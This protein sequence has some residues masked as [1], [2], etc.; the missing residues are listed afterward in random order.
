MSSLFKRTDLLRHAVDKY[1]AHYSL[2]ELK[3]KVD[4]KHY[5]IHEAYNMFRAA[6]PDHTKYLVDGKPLQQ[7]QFKSISGYMATLIIEEA[8][9]NPYGFIL[10]FNCGVLRPFKQ[11]LQI[12]NFRKAMDHV[13]KD[14][15]NKGKY[16]FM[17]RWVRDN[18]YSN[19]KFKRY[20]RYKPSDKIKDLFREHV[21]QN[22]SKNIIEATT[23]REHINAYIGYNLADSHR[24]Q[25]K[26]TKWREK[27]SSQ[28]LGT[29]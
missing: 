29:P 7:K 1:K 15:Y 18:Y 28:D 9:S 11:V 8:I 20:Y 19:L 4:Y 16:V 6:Y 26:I 21:K 5:T 25:S 17:V 24:Y 23:L 12:K 10:P 14:W 2:S 13:R 27:K 22:G 3:F